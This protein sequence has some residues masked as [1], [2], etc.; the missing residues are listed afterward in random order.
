MTLIQYTVFLNRQED[1]DGRLAIF[2]RLRTEDAYQPGD[3]L[4]EVFSSFLFEEEDENTLELLFSKFN[5]G[6]PDFVGDDLYPERSL[7][8]GDVVEVNGVRYACESAGWREIEA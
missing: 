2:S 5:R 8:V 3:E 1:T 6:A 4:E 7:S